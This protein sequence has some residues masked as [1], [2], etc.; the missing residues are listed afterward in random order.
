MK[1]NRTSGII[2]HPTSL[3]G[4]DGIGDLGPEAYLWL[5]FLADCGC[6]HWQV[7]PLGPTGYGDSPYQCFSAF[8]GNPYLISPT[9]LLDEHL[10]TREDLADRP[11]FP[12]E[13]VDF[14][15][16]IRWKTTLLDRSY[17][18]F[19]KSNAKNIKIEFEKF[20][21][22][23]AAWLDDF[24]LFMS[25]KEQQG[26][27][28]WIE[29]PAELRQRDQTALAAF[30][31]EQSDSI[32]RHKFRQ[33]LFFRQWEKLHLYAKRKGI[34]IIGDVPIFVALDSADAWSHTELFHMDAAGQ[35]TFVAGV[36]PDYFSPT[37]QLWGNPLY[38]WQVHQSSGY[39]WWIQRVQ[40]ALKLFDLIRLDH[41]RGF[42]GYWEVPYGKLTAEIGRW[43]KGPGEEFFQALTM[44]FGELPIIAE[45]LGEITPDVVTLRDQFALPGM[46]ILQFAFAGDADDPF[47]PHNY[48]VNCV[49]YSGTHDN[50]TSVGWYRNVTEK[51]RDFYRRYMARSGED[52]AWDL[53]RGVWSSVA[54]IAL[55]PMQDFL[56]L[57]SEARMNYPG[58]P[59][60]NWFWRI[61]P[62]AL[63]SKLQERIFENNLL[64]SRLPA[65][66]K[67]KKITTPQKKA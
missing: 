40:A 55:A 19:R 24:G 22:Q 15:E 4:P 46:K 7:L 54:M 60:G 47:L 56:S 11:E 21:E 26:G 29:W 43:V 17:A 49:A 67:P 20:V 1:F 10:L 36:P 13:R 48:P 34:S 65:R 14:G 23:E 39:A 28:S 52:V 45:D 27:G 63:S 44:A 32:L 62:T 61:T 5:N 12:I 64:Y 37:G 41:F 33:F 25:I 57:D 42:A 35:P 58:R 3:P 30:Q 53:I 50:D 6:S 16:V 2:L 8:A 51:E 31:Q 66:M 59:S 18:N 9:L 38:N